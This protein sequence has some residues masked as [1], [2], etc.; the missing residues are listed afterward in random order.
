MT[1]GAARTRSAVSLRHAYRLLNP[2]PTTLVTSAHGGKQ[3]V[4]AAAWVM[5]IDFDPPR[6]AAVVAEGT[7]T[8]TLVDASG[9][10]GLSVPGR[11]LLDATYA[12]GSVSGRDVDKLA[13]LETFAAE[14][15]AAPLIAG[16]VAWL[17]CRVLESLPK[18]DLFI[19][20][21]L[22]AWADD[23]HFANGEWRRADT[24]HHVNKGVFFATGERLEARR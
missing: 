2:G 1:A 3:N 15:I 13:K 8:R 4:M 20:E 22:A 14:R 18:Y 5:P 11:A 23:E 17:E 24:L 16:A 7:Y 12:V 9:E 6:V 10:L 19:C 21:V